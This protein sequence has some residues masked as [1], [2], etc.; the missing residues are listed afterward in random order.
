MTEGRRL[1]KESVT[2][3]IGEF[4]SK[5]LSFLL[6]PVYASYLS[7]D[8]FA[9]L[10]IVTMI[11]PVVMILLGRSFA[12]YLM[13]GYYEA[14][15]RKGFLGTL[16]LFG[17]CFAFV[18][19]IALHLA[20]PAIFRLFFKTISYRPYLQFGVAFGFFRLCYFYVITVYRTMRCP[21]M[22]VFLSIIQFVILSLAALG[23]VYLFRMD[24]LGI[25]QVQLFFSIVILLIFLLIIWRELARPNQWQSI[26]KALSFSYP[27][28]IHAFAGW[29]IIYV[30][31]IFIERSMSSIELS[32]Y[33]VATQIAMILSVLNNGVNQAWV[34]FVYANAEK[35]SFPQLFKTNAQKLV[36]FL[37]V[38]G[39]G[40]LLF[41]SDLILLMGKSV[42]QTA[43]HLLPVILL[44]YG[45]QLLYFIYVSILMY[46]KRTR[47]MPLISGLS[48]LISLLLNIYLI[49]VLGMQG[50]TLSTLAAYIVMFLFVKHLT[51]SFGKL[52]IM[53]RRFLISILVV[54]VGI[55][56]NFFAFRYGQGPELFVGKIAL[57]C[58]MT[59]LIARIHRVNYMEFLK[60][61]LMK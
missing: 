25:L 20:G 45:F 9:V 4:L 47:W 5:S 13:R 6:L 52:T 42:Y 44:A 3:I 24:L 8:D 1:S 41:S 18:L 21:K 46:R 56:L 22:S 60:N 49:P 33:T 14:E 30:S 31:R 59:F 53:D 15:D 36:L 7:V 48:G 37:L 61:F 17:F 10:S 34:P 39:L 51:R 27:L 50:A 19:S 28:F 57:I 11:W 12:G 23:S 35:E 2:Y 54:A 29:M 58:G 40:I 26:P 32:I 16:L 43:I 55:G 38:I